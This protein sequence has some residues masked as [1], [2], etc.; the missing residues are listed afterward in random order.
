MGTNTTEE[1]VRL[2]RVYHIRLELLPRQQTQLTEIL[3]VHLSE[4]LMLLHQ[5]AFLTALMLVTKIN[6]L[7]DLAAMSLKMETK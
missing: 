1:A 4:L 5:E 6:L 7:S 3:L 2:I